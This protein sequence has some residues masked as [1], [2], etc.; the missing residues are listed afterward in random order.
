MISRPRSNDRGYADAG[1]RR[2]QVDDL[3]K[4]RR[5][6]DDVCSAHVRTGIRI[7][8]VGPDDDVPEAV[9]VNVAD[10]DPL[11][12]AAIWLGSVDG[13][14]ARWNSIREIGVEVEVARP[15]HDI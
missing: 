4:R 14:N 1:W 8:L 13:D 6:K 5:A 9:A 3:G 11:S 12:Q 7:Q 2:G 10:I 15:Q